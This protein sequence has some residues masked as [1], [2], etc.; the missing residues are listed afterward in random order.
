MKRNAVKIVTNVKANNTSYYFKNESGIWIP[1]PESSPL[2]RQFYTKTAFA[3]RGREIIQKIDELY[4]RKNKGID[5]FFVGTAADYAYLQTVCSELLQGRDYQCR[6]S[7]TNVA[8]I[9]KIGSGKTSL[10]DGIRH[11]HGSEFVRSNEHGTV[12]Y[13][14]TEKNEKWYEIK[15][16]GLEPGEISA[17]YETLSELTGEDLSHIV[18]CLS[19]TNAKIEAA[20]KYFIEKTREDFP[21]L[22]II[23]ALTKCVD[24]DCQI[25]CDYIEREIDGIE[26]FPT[27]A[28]PFRVRGLRDSAG[29]EICIGTFGLEALYAFIAE[30]K[31]VTRHYPH[32]P[33]SSAGDH[34][35]D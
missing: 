21:D 20:E 8:V 31:R 7:F 16:I 6:V 17:A 4:N 19:G 3:G 28:Q 32:A 26:V 12:V 27:L 5:L 18:Y 29:H 30:G 24:E 9:G 15:G 13:T 25:L 23:V 34:D 33:Y 35:V 14:D 1:V 22:S 11:M 10:I 2:S